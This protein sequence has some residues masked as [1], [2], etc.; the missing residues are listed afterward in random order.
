MSEYPGTANLIHDPDFND[1]PGIFFR[2]GEASFGKVTWSITIDS[3]GTARLY[4][5][6]DASGTLLGEEALDPAYLW[7]LRF[8]VSDG[9]S[10]GFSAGD[11]QLNL[12]DFVAMASGQFDLDGD[13]V[14]DSVDNCPNTPNP[15]Q[16][17]SDTDGI[18][19]ACEGPCMLE[20]DF[21]TDPTGSPPAG[22]TEYYHGGGSS[23]PEYTREEAAALGV[24][25]SVD[26]AT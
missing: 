10:A 22:W 2:E 24:T 13:G 18:G 17:D 11:A 21:D 5:G 7:Y 15:D 4:D 20:G 25:I 14:P 9:T 3:T 23:P 1:T 19:D 8:M 16:A 12:Y 26:D 6:P